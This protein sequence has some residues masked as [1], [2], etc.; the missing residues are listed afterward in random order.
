MG[1]RKVQTFANKSGGISNKKLTVKISTLSGLI[2]KS[3]LSSTRFRLN[4]ANPSGS[5]FTNFTKM[6]TEG[7]SFQVGYFIAII[8]NSISCP[9]TVFLNV[10]VIMAV[11][12]RPSLQSNTNTLLACLAVTDALTGLTVQPSFIAWKSFLL[13]NSIHTTEAK[14]FH[15]FLIRALSVCSALHLALVTCERLIAIKFTMFYHDIV[16]KHNIKMAVMAIWAYTL[17]SE[18]MRVVLAHVRKNMQSL[19]VFVTWI[20]CVVFITSAYAILYRETRRHEKKIKNQ[21]L[22]QE[23]VERFAKESK[24]LKT[25]VFV[26]G[27]VVLSFLPMALT[28]SLNITGLREIVTDKIINSILSPIVRTF[29]MLNSLLNPLIYCLRQ[30]EMRKFVLR[31]PCLAVEPAME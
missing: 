23:E 27:A 25:T 10:L 12:R 8:I 14:D 4:M 17:T 24:A 29:A 2:N 15:N 11:K 7:D 3:D 31:V 16:T 28:V 1:K 22:P 9:C 30:K 26:V 20:V 19:L 21:Q 6:T 5:N 18:V 13:Q